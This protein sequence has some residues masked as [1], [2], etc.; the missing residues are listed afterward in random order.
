MTTQNTS[1]SGSVSTI[2]S[3]RRDHCEG[4]TGGTYQEV[5]FVVDFDL[6]DLASTAPVQRRAH[7]GQEPL[8]LGAQLVGI[9]LHAKSGHPTRAVEAASGTGDRLHQ[10]D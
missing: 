8:T 5:R 2:Q 4:T 1:P 7:R 3:L 9:D 6:P 10:G